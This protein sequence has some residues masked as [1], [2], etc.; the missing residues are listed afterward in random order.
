MSA[1]GDVRLD[2]RMG[3]LEV[4]V[5]EPR[6]TLSTKLDSLAD[7]M[8]PRAADVEARLRVLEG[9]RPDPSHEAR[10]SKLEQWRWL[11]TGA[12]AAGGGAAGWLTS[13]LWPK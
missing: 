11:I 7:R 9:D 3:A 1:V 10:L 4:A 2:Q 13:T 12:A 8:E 6:A 5:A